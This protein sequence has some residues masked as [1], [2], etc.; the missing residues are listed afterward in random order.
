MEALQARGERP[1]FQRMNGSKC[2]SL[3]LGKEDG[4]CV[5]LQS[6]PTAQIVSSCSM[7]IA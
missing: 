5:V 1:D 4:G 7:V 6:V 3:E 2:H